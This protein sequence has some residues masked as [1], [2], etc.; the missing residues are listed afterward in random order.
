[1]SLPDCGPISPILKKTPIFCHCASYNFSD[2]HFSSSEIFPIK[3]SDNI[4][5]KQLSRSFCG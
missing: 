5:I 4:R 1:M 3:K 2:F